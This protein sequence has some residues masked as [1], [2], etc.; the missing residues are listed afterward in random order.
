M[1]LEKPYIRS[2]NYYSENNRPR[3]SKYGCEIL[4]TEYNQNKS[5]S[6]HK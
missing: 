2:I 1:R 5:S 3:T 4:R 6:I